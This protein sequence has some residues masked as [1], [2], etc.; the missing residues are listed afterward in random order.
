M[1][2]R[3]LRMKKVQAGMYQTW[4]EY[5]HSQFLLTIKGANTSD[6][7]M[8]F[9]MA[10]TDKE[11]TRA[12]LHQLRQYQHCIFDTLEPIITMHSLDNDKEICLLE[13]VVKIENECLIRNLQKYDD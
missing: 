13:I 9:E 2:F 11:N 6:Y 1:I 7:H 8:T 5:E 10:C 12:E 3:N 4:F